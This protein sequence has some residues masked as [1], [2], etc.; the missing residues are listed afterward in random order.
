MQI[1]LTK[2]YSAAKLTHN[3]W[4]TYWLE[5][6]REINFSGKLTKIFVTAFLKGTALTCWFNIYNLLVSFAYILY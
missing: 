1:E 6:F 5:L 2:V 3:F 4:K